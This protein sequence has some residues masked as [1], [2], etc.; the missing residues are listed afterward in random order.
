M[1]LQEALEQRYSCRQFSAEEPTRDQIVAVLEAGRLAPTACNAQSVRLFVAQG[2]EALAKIDVATHC[3]YGAPVCVIVGYD[4]AVAPM[5]DPEKYNGTEFSF[6][7]Q[8]ATSVLLHMA[9]KATDLGLATCWLGAIDDAA[10]HAEFG[11]P[12]SVA[13]RA[14][15]DLGF[16]GEKGG[17]SPKH[18]DR[19]P[20]E[21]TVTWL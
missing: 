19:K 13:I 7:D 21:E 11:I 9:L 8:D 10:L 12:E 4:T 2:A 3:R 15:L 1:E 18:T 20:L 16:A 6:G 14:V 5:H 17:P